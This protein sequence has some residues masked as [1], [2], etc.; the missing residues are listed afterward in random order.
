MQLSAQLSGRP[1]DSTSVSSSALPSGA[2]TT[3]R[4]ALALLLP[5]VPPH[6][7]ATAGPGRAD[8]GAAAEGA[9]GDASAAFVAL[10][11]G[12]RV[13]LETPLAWL[14]K[15]CGHPDGFLYVVVRPE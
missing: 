7:G 9:G 5:G 3:L 14:W 11:Q 10:V 12:V 4:D 15:K 8:A 13:A 2:A 6:E 1:F